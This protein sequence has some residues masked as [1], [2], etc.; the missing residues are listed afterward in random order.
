MKTIAPKKICFVIG[1]GRS[2]T[3]LLSKLLNRHPQV[4]A[5]PEAVFLIF[6]LEAYKNKDQFTS[7][8]IKLVFEQIKWFSYTHPWV[9]WSFDMEAVKNE[10]LDFVNGKKVHYEELCK[11]IYTRFKV[12]SM[13][14]SA[15]L[16]LADK[17]PS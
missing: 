16:W 9:G 7:E 13:D 1:M 4:H 8:E 2:G 12:N 14:K 17:N 10:T 3:T 11:F 5:T 6:F 15:A